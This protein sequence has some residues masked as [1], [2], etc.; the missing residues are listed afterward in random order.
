MTRDDPGT[1][2]N[3]KPVRQHA[4]MHARTACPISDC[5]YNPDTWNDRKA[6]SPAS[7]REAL[8]AAIE[9]LLGTVRPP[10]TDKDGIVAWELA[11][12]RLRVAYRAYRGE[13]TMCPVPSS[14]TGQP[15]LLPDGHPMDSAV[16][17]HR[18][19]PPA[20]SGAESPASGELAWTIV[21]DTPDS[22]TPEPE[23]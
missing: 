1:I 22:P 11:A 8:D 14:V 2:V 10:S 19:A 13:V 21:E 20:L 17:F 18:Y 4:P 9:G 7:L 12:S 16:R 6:E 3:G 5:D 15:C 23:R